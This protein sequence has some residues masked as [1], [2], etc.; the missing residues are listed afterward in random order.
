MSARSLFL[1]FEPKMFTGP[2]KMAEDDD[3]L[4]DLINAIEQG[5]GNVKVGS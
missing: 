4:E 5:A 3:D 1:S 2:E